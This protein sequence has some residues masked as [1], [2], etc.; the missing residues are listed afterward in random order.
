M[1]EVFSQNGYAT[2]M[3]GKWDLGF[4][5]PQYLPTA[6]GFDSYLGYLFAENYYYSKLCPVDNNFTDMTFSTT[7]CY[8]QYNDEDLHKYSTYFYKDHAIDIINN[9]DTSKPLFLFLAFQAVHSPFIDTYRD[10]EV[11]PSDLDEVVYD[12]IMTEVDV[13]ICDLQLYE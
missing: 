7:E 6:R 4:Y 8:Y 12:R 10:M 9:H 5:T 13:S 11:S 3:L 2:H 1:S